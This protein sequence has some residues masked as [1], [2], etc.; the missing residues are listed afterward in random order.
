[1]NYNFGKG[2]KV[3]RSD[4][5]LED[6]GVSL[7]TGVTV[8]DQFIRWGKEIPET[9]FVAHTP[10]TSRYLLEAMLGHG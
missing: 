3:G 9:K 7:D 10:G 1:M 6:R 4:H 8:K 5:H 2:K